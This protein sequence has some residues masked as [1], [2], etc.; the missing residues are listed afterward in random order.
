MFL[1]MWNW[2][3]NKYNQYC[4]GAGMHGNFQKHSGPN[5]MLNNNA[6]ITFILHFFDS[7][8]PVDDVFY[9]NAN[10]IL[11]TVDYD[12]EMQRLQEYGFLNAYTTWT[13]PDQ[14]GFDGTVLPG[15]K[16]IFNNGGRIKAEV[17]QFG[18]PV[19][20][21]RGYGNGV[22]INITYKDPW[23]FN[24]TN[25]DIPYGVIEHILL[26]CFSAT[27][28]SVIEIEDY[29]FTA[30]INNNFISPYEGK[31]G[32]MKE[33]NISDD[34][35]ARRSSLY[36][37]DIDFILVITSIATWKHLNIID[38]T[39]QA[40]WPQISVGMEDYL[41]KKQNGYHSFSLGHPEDKQIRTQLWG[42]YWNQHYSKAKEAE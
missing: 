12:I 14:I 26:D 10:E 6:L 42:N 37:C 8:T 30:K 5:Y 24:I 28:H 17:V 19:I 2:G 15:T 38:V 34:G 20:I 13:T 32:M 1:F 27:C 29:D 39:T 18:S 7:V 31:L 4:T 25:T 40:Y 22:K 36:H 33:F 35:V 16:E 41:Y 21:N 3:C 23:N 11:N 9:K